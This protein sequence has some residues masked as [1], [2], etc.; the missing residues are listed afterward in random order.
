MTE[1]DPKPHYSTSTF[2]KMLPFWFGVLAFFGF[3]WGLYEPYVIP[4]G[5]MIPN[6]LVY[7]HILVSKFSYGLRWPFTDKW[8]IGP[9]T[10]ERGDVVV[11]RSVKDPS[12]FMVK[13]VVGLPG[14][15][16]KLDEQNSLIINGESVEFDSLSFESVRETLDNAVTDKDLRRSPDSFEFRREKFANSSHIVQVDRNSFSYDATFKVPEGEL[17]VLGDNRDSSQDSRFWG[18]L[19]KENLLGR[20]S[21][22]WLSCAKAVRNQQILCDPRQIRW[23][24]IFSAIQ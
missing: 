2:R 16:L 18:S 12:F 22:I 11:F 23:H 21:Y 13:R 10:P 14:D 20:A 3:R 7:D 1:E 24:R 5:S 15:E 8:M 17:F 19:P 6:L 9:S 4:S